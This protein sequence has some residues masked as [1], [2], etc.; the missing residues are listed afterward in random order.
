[1]Q[2]IKDWAEED[3]PREKLINLGKS[4]LSNS[5]L[6]AILL[7][8]GTKGMNVI[9]LSKKI[10]ADHNNNLNE[11]GKIDVNQLIK[12][13]KGI[14]LAKAVNVVA[15]LELGRRREADQALEK[16]KIES[17]SDAYKIFKPLVE[18]MP[19]EEFWILL[20]NRANKVI[21]KKFI[22]KGG[23]SSV[24]VDT[25]LIMI[26]ALEHRASAIILCHNHPSGQMKPSSQDIQI[27][28]KIKTA[29]QL[30]DIGLL[31]HIILGDNTYYSFADEGQL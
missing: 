22:G 8:T 9:E 30:L 27:T 24:V 15:C 17:S 19:H 28:Q 29:A 3:R 2:K 21:G 26:A 16:P 10:L 6:L 13:Y 1:M 18:D 5:D 4:S 31:D 11:L 20:L 7:S 25:K 14:G 23:M 12:K